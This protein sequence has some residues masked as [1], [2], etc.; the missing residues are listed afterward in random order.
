MRGCGYGMGWAWMRLCVRLD[1][2]VMARGVGRV[3]DP[4]A[5][6]PQEKRVFCV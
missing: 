5:F 1:G 3:R 6:H 2:R 4:L